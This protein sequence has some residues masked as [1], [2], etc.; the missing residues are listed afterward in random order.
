MQVKAFSNTSFI[1]S[2]VDS[3]LSLWKDDGLRLK[4]VKGKLLLSL[5]AD[6][7]IVLFALEHFFPFWTLNIISAQFYQRVK[8]DGNY[9]RHLREY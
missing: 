9:H 3:G 7:E 1:T 4:G 8:R 2:S 6:V 5:N